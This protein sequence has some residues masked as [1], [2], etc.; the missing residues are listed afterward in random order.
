[1]RHAL[2]I[3][4]VAIGC[5]QALSAEP[6]P[7]EELTQMTGKFFELLK[8]DKVEQAYD[9]L[10]KGSKIKGK[11]ED[12]TQLK[13]QTREALTTFGP[14]LGFE[15]LDYKRKGFSLMQLVYFSWQDER[16]LRWRFTF[17]RPKDKWRLVNIQLDDQ[18]IQFW[19]ESSQKPSPTD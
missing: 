15:L 5:T 11:S 14:V 16:P 18:A 3:L 8:K 10:L 7:P 2:F 12:V 9:E 1:M 4:L 6:P 13:T 17:Y 19:D